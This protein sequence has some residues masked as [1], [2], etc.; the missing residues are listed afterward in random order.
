MLSPFLTDHHQ[1]SPTLAVP[2]LHS[3]ALTGNRQ[4][5]QTITG[6]HRLTPPITNSGRYSPALTAIANSRRTSQALTGSHR[7][8][9]TLAVPCL[10]SSALTGYHGGSKCG[11]M[12]I[13]MAPCRFACVSFPC[14]AKFPLQYCAVLSSVIV[15]YKRRPSSMSRRAFKHA[16]NGG[17]HYMDSRRRR[18]HADVHLPPY[19]G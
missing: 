18:L 14:L 3:P 11:F 8:S 4:L 7:V 6:S 5:S 9:P 12:H 19:R 17:L 2:C 16:E 13:C 15:Q 10:H 1:L